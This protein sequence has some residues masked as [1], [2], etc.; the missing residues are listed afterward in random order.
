MT[1]SIIDHL[2]V[3]APDL[4]TGV[5]YVNAR[6]GVTLQGGGEHPRMGTHNR[7]LRLGETTYLEVIAINPAAPPPGR[8]RWFA[9]DSL[10]ADSRPR[11]QTWVAR[12]NDILAAGRASDDRLGRIEPMSR[13]NLEWLISIPPDGNLIFD[14]VVPAL[15]EWGSDDHPAA[16]LADAGCELVGLELFHPQPEWIQALLDAI[17][18]QGPVSLARCAPSEGGYLVANLRTPSGLVRL[19]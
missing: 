1:A 17:G 8:P 2:V 5:D 3:T 10:A 7:L 14:G 18:F 4:D 16:K 19:S 15:I 9:L 6:L 13:G 12:T 11:L